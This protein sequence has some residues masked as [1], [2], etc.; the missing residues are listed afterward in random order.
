[1]KE[2]QTDTLN[3]STLYELN[4]EYIETCYY[5]SQEFELATYSKVLTLPEWKTGISTA[6]QWPV[7]VPRRQIYLSL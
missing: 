1:L 5:H 4:H 7:A 6:E 3:E 2:Q